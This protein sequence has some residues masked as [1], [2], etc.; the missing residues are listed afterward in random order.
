MMRAYKRTRAVCSLPLTDTYC[1]EVLRGAIL[2]LG[3]HGLQLKSEKARK[4]FTSLNG[5]RLQPERVCFEESLITR[6][7]ADMRARM[8]PP[9]P[10]TPFQHGYPWSGMY[11]A[12]VEQGRV[13]PAQEADLIRAVRFLDAYGVPGHVPPV[14]LGAYPPD[15][16]D[17]HSTRICLEHSPVYGAPTHTPEEQELDLYKQMA[18]VVKQKIWILAMLILNPLKFDDRVLEFVLAHHQDGDLKIEMTGGLPCVGST[19]PLV[20]PAVQ[21][22]N[23]AEGFAACL[24]IHAVTGEYPP[25]YLRSDPFDMRFMNYSVAG[26]EYALLDLANR[27]LYEY[28]CGI[29]R[30]WGYLVSMSRWPD[31][32]AAHERTVS[33]WLQAMN[34]ATV[35]HG[36]G[37]LASDEVFSLEQV[38]LDRTIVKGAERMVKGLKWEIPF[39]YSYQILEDGIVRGNYL[40]HDSTLDEYRDF[41]GRC[42]LFPAMNVGQWRDKGEPTPLTMAREIL[43]KY[44][45]QNTFYRDDDEITELRRICGEY[46]NPVNLRSS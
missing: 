10:D 41:F 15:L 43:D 14:I 22:Q 32:Q 39:E 28:L 9:D 33:C 8:S 44:L 34:G 2:L 19:A 36:T 16:R 30:D 42:E 35:F 46:V 18:Q 27:R 5:V 45:A 17:I 24:F 25:P 6:Y 40:E 21:I 38:V 1:E 12:D 11:W 13:R 31:Q 37:Q 20:F 3:E 26:P 23:L 29:P 4:F 7:I